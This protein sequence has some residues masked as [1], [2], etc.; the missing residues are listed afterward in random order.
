MT[1]TF[2]E[3]SSS[4]S[5]SSSVDNSIHP[6]DDQD[7]LDEVRTIPAAATASPT[8]QEETMI[9]DIQRLLAR[10]IGKASQ[11]L[12]MLAECWMHIRTKFDGGKQINRSQRGSWA[13]RCTGAGLRLNEGPMWGPQC[14]EKA[15]SI[16]AN[17]IFKSH[18]ATVS[19]EVEKDR[20]RKSLLKLTKILLPL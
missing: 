19:K 4:N 13:G 3:C 6:D 5:S 1:N 7:D 9:C 10:L 2:S 15:V 12:G 17:D 11:L 14:W 8:T 20:K 18:A 16:P